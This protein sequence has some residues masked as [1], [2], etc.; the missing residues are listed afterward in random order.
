MY[1][2]LRK[3]PKHYDF[4]LPW[5]GLEKAQHHYENPADVRAA[6]RMAKLYDEIK[7]DNPTKVHEEVHGMNVFLTRLLFCFFAE[8]TEIF[9]DGL[10]TKSISSHTQADGSDLNIYLE[11]LFE[12]LNTQTRSNLPAYLEVFPYVNGGLFKDNYKVPVFTRR[13]R[14]AIIES[15]ELDWSAIN[16]DIFG[17]M[18]QAVVTSEHRSGL[19]M[20]YTSVPNILNVIRPLFLDE[21]HEA[22]DRSQNNENKLKNLLERLSKIKIFDPACGSGNFLIIS[23]KEIRRLEMKIIKQLNIITHFEHPSARKMEL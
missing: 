8:D 18:I 9:D 13:S 17:S 12:V 14:Q 10:F 19:G 3:N 5:A 15:G 4:F 11:K 7:K 22:F 20:H 1:R 2:S 16:P 6:E 23:Y 21:L